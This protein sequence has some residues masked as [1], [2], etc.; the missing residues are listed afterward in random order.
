MLFEQ[1]ML[2]VDFPEYS[3]CL[4]NRSVIQLTLQT[5]FA[6]SGYWKRDY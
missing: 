3:L 2:G 5:I 1:A 6:E 4:R